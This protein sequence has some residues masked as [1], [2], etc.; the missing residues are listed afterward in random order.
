VGK[1][2]SSTLQWYKCIQEGDIPL[3]RDSH[4][5]AE[6]GNRLYVFGGQGDN[7]VIFDDLHS[8]DIVQGVTPE[9]EVQFTA[10]WKR[11]EVLPGL[12]PAARASHTCSAYKNRFIVVVG[13]EADEERPN[14][15]G[16][17]CKKK[18]KKH[19]DE[20]EIMISIDDEDEVSLSL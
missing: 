5:C 10:K 1:T 20:D 3:G 13:G 18:T 17:E 12:R 2:Q 16:E 9:G 11:I 19:A 15:I 6:I 8:V 14:L 4:S 7:D